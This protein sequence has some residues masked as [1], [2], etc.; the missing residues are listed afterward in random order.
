MNTV[1]SITASALT[2]CFISTL[3]LG[4][5]DMEV[6]LNATLAGG[7]AIGTSCD[8]LTYSIYPLC[9]GAFAGMISALGYLKINKF[10]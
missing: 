8:L 5:F 7:V 1:L 10:C 3:M 4:K 2:S 9:I 6:M